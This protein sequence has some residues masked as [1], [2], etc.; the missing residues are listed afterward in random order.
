MT[1][2][3]GNSAYFLEQLTRKIPDARIVHLTVAN[4][5]PLSKVNE[6]HICIVICTICITASTMKTVPSFEMKYYAK[7][8]AKSNFRI[9]LSALQMFDELCQ[10]HT[11]PVLSNMPGLGGTQHFKMVQLT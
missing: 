1:R 10:I 11:S 8:Y 3:Y 2:L 5:P 9:N 7:S 4:A 6:I